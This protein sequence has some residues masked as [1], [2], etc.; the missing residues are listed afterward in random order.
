V[1]REELEQKREE[2]L[3]EFERAAEQADRTPWISPRRYRDEVIPLELEGL[4]RV[5]ELPKPP[6]LFVLVCGTSPEPLEISYRLLGGDRERTC[7]YVV[8]AEDGPGRVVANDVLSRLDLP[9]DRLIPVD[10]P[11][12]LGAYA[13]LSRRLGDV[14]GDYDP[15]L[16]RPRPFTSRLCELRDPIAVF[17]LRELRG[18]R[19]QFMAGRY[20]LA[21][22]RLET[23]QRELAEQRLPP[24]VVDADAI[25]RRR[26]VCEGWAAWDAGDFAEAKRL[27]GV[28]GLHLPPGAERLADGWESLMKMAPGKRPLELAKAPSGGGRPGERLLRFCA[29]RIHQAALHARSGS[30]RGARGE[31]ADARE[32]EAFLRAYATCDAALNGL[33]QH[34]LQSERWRPTRGKAKTWA[35]LL[36]EKGGKVPVDQ[37]AIA[38]RDGE[39]VDGLDV[40]GVPGLGAPYDETLGDDAFRA[41]RNSFEHAI[42]SIGEAQRSRIHSFLPRREGD[43]PGQAE[44]LLEAVARAFGREDWPA[45]WAEAD[46][47]GALKESLAM[48]RG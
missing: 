15:R 5:V 9:S 42:G 4:R 37:L 30:A 3:D 26:T 28:A 16:G 40:K 41:L 31:S 13:E 27:M 7:T 43:E 23:I 38:I 12:P 8:G 39:S 20:A 35:D 11:D 46:P 6:R 45:I 29:D 34:L 14:D 1:D 33:V 25:A 19:E 2:I 47:S 18:I 44:R 32:I 48:I 10:P 22:E 24:G 21:A 36:R 17:R